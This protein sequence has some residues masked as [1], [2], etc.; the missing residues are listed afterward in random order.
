MLTS[1]DRNRKRY[2]IPM[3]VATFDLKLSLQ[4]GQK[5]ISYSE[6]TVKDG[7]PFMTTLAGDVGFE[8]TERRHLYDWDRIPCDGNWVFKLDSI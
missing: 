5:N 2:D 4:Q 6:N 3:N 1:T 7:I 8:G